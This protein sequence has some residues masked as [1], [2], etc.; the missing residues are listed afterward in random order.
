VLS[1]TCAFVLIAALSQD[2]EKSIK[3]PI[4]GNEINP[5]AFFTWSPLVILSIYL[6]LQVYIQELRG[7]FRR[8]KDFENLVDCNG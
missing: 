3:L 7:R 2:T 1:T 4:I 8:L 5:G 6:Y